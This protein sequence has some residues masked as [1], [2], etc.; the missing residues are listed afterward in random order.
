MKFRFSPEYRKIRNAKSDPIL[1][2]IKLWL[3]E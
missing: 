2:I 3:L 1:K